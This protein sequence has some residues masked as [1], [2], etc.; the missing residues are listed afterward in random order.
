MRSGV[1]QPQSVKLTAAL[2][3]LRIYVSSRVAQCN[4]LNYTL[5]DRNDQ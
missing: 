1:H 2:D 4:T 5:A 3:A